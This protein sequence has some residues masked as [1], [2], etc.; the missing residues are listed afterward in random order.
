MQGSVAVS[1][2]PYGGT[3]SLGIPNRD[4]TYDHTVHEGS[5]DVPPVTMAS[6][7]GPAVDR[8]PARQVGN[9][10]PTVVGGSGQLAGRQPNLGATNGDQICLCTDASQTDWVVHWED[11]TVSGQ[12]SSPDIDH[13]NAL[14]ESGIS[15][16]V[17]LGVHPPPPPPPSPSGGTRRY[18]FDQTMSS[19]CNI[20]TVKEG[21]FP[22]DCVTWQ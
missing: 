2:R 21:Q 19:Q 16:G 20:S 7:A 13:I 11:Q 14:D 8:H 3:G 4:R 9:P 18:W 1:Q 15:G 5:L 12:W 22:P 10:E 17:P 6:E